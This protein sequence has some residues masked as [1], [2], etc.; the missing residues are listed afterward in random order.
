MAYIGNSPALKYA[1]FAVQHFTTSAT[2]GYTLDNAVTNENGIALFINNVRQQP[3]SSYAYTVSGTT[4]TLSAATTTSDTMYCVFI[5]KAVQ[6][7]IPPVG[8]VGTSQLAALGVTNAKIANSTVDLTAKVTGNLPVGNLNSG[9]SASSSTFWRGDGTW[10]APSGGAQISGTPANNQLAIWTA[11]DTI[12]GDSNII[13]NAA[14]DPPALKLQNSR[15]ELNHSGDGTLYL[16]LDSNRG[17]AG[18]HIGELL[19]NWDGT[20]VAKVVAKAGADTTNKDDATLAF[21]T[22]PSGGSITERLE[23][24]SAGRGKSVFTGLAWAHFDGT[25]TPSIQASHN[26]ADITDSETGQMRVNFTASLAN[27]NYSAVVNGWWGYAY[28]GGAMDIYTDGFKATTSNGSSYTD[29]NS[30]MISV[31]G[32]P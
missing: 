22:T 6:T 12:E 18:D 4:L 14:L 32:N 3:G 23:I 13:Y 21:F 28:S 8:S 30:I 16:T 31:F 26:V 11:A 20:S 10:V 5:G 29:V 17:A 19:F 24:T 9:T 2:T 27:A 25:G 1:S 7:V 15:L